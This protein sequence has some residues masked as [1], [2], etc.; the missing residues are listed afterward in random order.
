MNSNLQPQL[1]AEL[2]ESD[3]MGE[4]ENSWYKPGRASPRDHQRPF[5]LLTYTR[6]LWGTESRRVGEKAMEQWGACGAVA[7]LTD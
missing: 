6:S 7:E 4:K 2:L 1:R 5:T 3:S